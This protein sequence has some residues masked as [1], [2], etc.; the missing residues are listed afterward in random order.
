LTTAVLENVRRRDAKAVVRFTTLDE[1]CPNPA[2]WWAGI[3]RKTP[4]R[5]ECDSRPAWGVFSLRSVSVRSLQVRLPWRTISGRL[6]AHG[7]SGIGPGWPS[8]THREA[9][10]N[11]YS[12]TMIPVGVVTNLPTLWMFLSRIGVFVP[13]MNDSSPV[14]D[15]H[16]PQLVVRLMFFYR[17]RL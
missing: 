1:D 9:T 13:F 3:M 2:S 14:I 5:A 11:Y 7:T 17:P 15:V 16:F 4:H 8:L 12:P 10:S 6:V